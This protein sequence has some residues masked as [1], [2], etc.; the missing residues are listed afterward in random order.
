[1]E[2]K[3]F[4]EVLKAREAAEAARHNGQEEQ[5]Q[6]HLDDTQRVKV[7]SPAR[8]VVKRFLR[9]KLAIIGSVIL[10]I[11]F[12]FSFLCPLFYSYG[13]TDIFYKYDYL[14]VD[15]AS[16]TKRTE[17]TNYVYDSN[18]TVNKTISNKMTSMIS[19][20][21]SVGARMRVE[22]ADGEDYL[23]ENLGDSVYTLSIADVQITAQKGLSEAIGTYNKMLGE[24]NY[25]ADVPGDDF[26]AAVGAAIAAGNETF[27]YDGSDYTVTSG[28]VK[29]TYNVTR[30]AGDGLSYPNGN[31]GEGFEAAYEGST[32][33]TF[34]F[35]GATYVIAADGDTSVIYK[36]N[37]TQTALVSSPFVFDTYDTSLSLSNELKAEAL[38]ALHGAGSFTMDGV[39]YHTALEEDS[40]FL[41]E[42]GSEEPIA[43]LSDF[44][45]RR[46]NGEDTLSIEFKAAAQ[47]T[48]E[49]MEAA[50]A[51]TG[52]FHFD[53]PE[54]DENGD[55]LLDENGEPIYLDTEITVTQKTGQ[56]VLNCEQLTHLID[57]YA[58]PSRSHIFGTDADGMD[59]LARM[60]YGGRISLMVGFVVVIL[61]CVLGVLLGGLAGYFGGWVDT[62]IMRLV[63][64]FYCIPSM[65]ILIILGAFFD[66]M[67]MGSY[68]R[69]MWMMAV[70]GFLGWAG[71]ARLV[72]GQILSLREQEFMTATEAT[73][74]STSR[75]IF[76]HLIP[77]VMPQ[78]IVNATMG[79]GSIIIT[80]STLSFLGLGVKHPLA[81]WGT[82]INSITSSNENIIR[83][84]YIWIP[85]GCLICLTVIAFNFVGDGL[86]DAFDPK[87]KQ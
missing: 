35:G 49:E 33:S 32:D 50:D 83:Y 48:I 61:E 69:L 12:A 6:M 86:R 54:M 71:V 38:L 36:V 22:S 18:L 14:S 62:L 25:T 66:N 74:I 53:L 31:P 10:I 27:Q 21:E 76:R 34:E 52:T 68:T 65:P 70:L 55:Y 1:M 23:I 45:V 81:T 51:K 60:M 16:A 78:L 73:G 59:V 24:L 17:Y 2:K 7:L 85:V 58:A 67:R 8:L 20:M 42:D 72:R 19:S 40:Y 75:R 39:S 29:N 4:N 84:A 64:V 13:Q 77:N 47:S 5:E 44:A 79:L 46:Y 11:M 82:M 63:D 9:N 37:S 3:N 41:Y 43:I 30:G 28:S 87:M 56:Y 26:A 15:Y 57:I 80:E